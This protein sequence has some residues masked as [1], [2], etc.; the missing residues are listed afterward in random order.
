MKKTGLSSRR[1]FIART[2]VTAAA[3]SVVPGTVLKLRGA[4]S[5]NNKLNLA[6]IGVSGRGGDDIGELASENIVALCDVDDWHA[7]ATYKKFP[8]AKRYSDYRKMLD[9]MDKEIDAVLVATPDHTHAAAVLR[10][11]QM[12][13]HVYC[14]KPLA[15][16]VD[17]LRRIKAA[18]SKHKV[19][20]QMGNQGHSFDS[21]RTFKEWIEDGLIGDV[22]EVHAFC[23]SDYSRIKQLSR[24]QE[25]HP[26]PTTLNWDLWLGPVKYRDYHPLYLPGKWRGWTAF[27]TGVL[28]DWT[29]HVMDPVFWALD[30]GAPSSITADTG[31]YDPALHGET[32]PSASVITYEFPAKN[33]RPAVKLTWFDGKQR[34]PQPEEMGP[35]KPLPGIGAVVIG[36]KGKIVYGSHGAGG[37]KLLPNALMEGRSQA[38]QRIPRSPGHHKE[39][40]EAC[41][42]GS[43]TGSNFQYGADLAELALLGSV[44]I[45][46]KNQ[47]LE[48]NA[49]EMKF[50]NYKPANEF[51][52][53][54][55][56]PGWGM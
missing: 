49:A 19:A 54:E 41:K 25:K 44:A 22:R 31:D 50:T 1:D 30:L 32:F 29:C 17:E 4:A 34:P 21:I 16:T 2:A 11:L 28:G 23:S 24:L 39:W 38:P 40:I 43:P 35:G 12:N 42:T 45:R 26:I 3:L 8:N 10:A 56:R 47:R 36:N 27:G 20:T 15:H 18:A 13:K 33:K 52:R 5:P 51:L 55:Y 14:E 48:W 53:K 37:L 7:S 9:A 6:C 46:C